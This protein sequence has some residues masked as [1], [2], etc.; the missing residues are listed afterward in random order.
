MILY[1]IYKVY[2]IHPFFLH[3]FFCISTFFCMNFE[4]EHAK[5]GRGCNTQI[6]TKTGAIIGTKS[7]LIV[8]FQL[9]YYCK[10]T[11]GTIFFI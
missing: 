10:T 11:L 1:K 3:T 9:V 8:I 5:K 2:N 7:T 6:S 4:V